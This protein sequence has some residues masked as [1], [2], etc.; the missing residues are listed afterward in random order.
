MKIKSSVTSVLMMSAIILISGLFSS[1]N[2]ASSACAQG[3]GEGRP[4]GQ[5]LSPE[6]QNLAKAIMTA[7]DPAAKL[8][9]AAE[10]NRNYPKTSAPPRVAQALLDQISGVTAAS[11]K[12]NPAQAYPKVL[13]HP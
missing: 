12:A 5:N 2:I 11:Q 1:G 4:R 6:E 8:Q 13:D 3:R 10:L 7:A 9:A